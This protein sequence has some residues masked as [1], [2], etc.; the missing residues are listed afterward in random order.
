M[1]ES[2]HNKLKR[3]RKP[4][5]HITYDVET[6]GAE[7]KKELPFVAGVM[8]DY[9]GDNAE[10][11]KALKER[12]FVQVDRDNFNE[13]MAKVNPKL[14]LQV[15]NTLAGDGNTMAVDL[16]FRK[17]D[18]FTPEAI[19]EQVEPLKQLLDARNKLRDLLSKADRSEE[20]ETVLE[21]ILK[22][23]DNITEISQQL[24]VGESKEGAE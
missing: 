16:D 2:I 6:N 10:N 7:V 1:S 24:G 22:N 9:S 18:D 19:V 15:E 12:K 3:V 17:M 4:R 21:Q 8:G 5:V 14:N 20:L 11:R 23:T 13:V